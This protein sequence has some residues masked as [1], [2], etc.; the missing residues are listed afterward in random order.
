[1]RYLLSKQF[2][3]DFAKLPKPIKQKVILTLEQFIENPF[4]P[5]LRNHSLS[6]RWKGHH[7]LNVTGDVRAVYVFIEN[8]MVYFIAIGTHSELYK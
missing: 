3:K 2:E 8:D 1:M 5:S 6:G 4:A 7:S